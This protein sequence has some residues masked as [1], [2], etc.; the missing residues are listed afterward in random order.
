MIRAGVAGLGKM[1]ASHYAIINAH[2]DVDLVSVCDTSGLILNAI[3][4]FSTLRTFK[5]YQ[6]MIEQCNLDCIIIATPTSL[7]AEMIRFALE[8]N[9][10]VFVEKPFCLHLED[11]QE[12]VNLAS[13][14]HLVN[15]VGYHYRFVGTFRKT[16]EL[17]EQKAIGE[18]YHFTAEAYGPVVLKAEGST[19]RTKRSEGGGCLH[20]Y[21]SHVIDIVNYLIGP[22][23]KVSGTVLKTIYSRGVEDAVYSTLLYNDGLSGQLAVN[24]SEETYRKMSTQVEI[25]GTKGKII[26]DRQEFK[27]Y[28][29]SNDGFSE[30]ESGW[31]ILYT[32]DLTKPVWFYL[33]GEE[34]SDQLDYFVESIKNN[35]TDNINSFANAIR[36][37]IAINLL[38]DDARQRTV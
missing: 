35:K 33:R 31:N 19:W 11:G 14:R 18:V 6:K 21:A 16:K 29:K 1:G 10:H 17:L 2:P 13:E 24:W 30:L 5:N 8:H 4:K 38:M 22:P 25:Y 28:L 36:T 3:D 9:V 7:H 26:A 37:D 20:D 23:D 34:Y 15:Q 12:L 32:T 27:I